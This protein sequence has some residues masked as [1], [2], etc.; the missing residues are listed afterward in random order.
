MNPVLPA[1]KGSGAW[2]GA[3]AGLLL[4]GLL[5]AGCGGPAQPA[6]NGKQE[7]APP[8]VR[9]AVIEPRPVEVRITAVGTIE[10]ENRVIVAAQEEGL[11][12]GL[13][14]REGD[15]LRRGD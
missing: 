9:A 10:P 8:E 15:A 13:R 7:A 12:T 4:A 14:V 1:G 2:Q 3:L 11:I 5:A 6:A